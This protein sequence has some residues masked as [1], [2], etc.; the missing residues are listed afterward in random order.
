M[1]KIP[2][3]EG[4][5]Q[6]ELA[7]T[8]ETPEMQFFE[9][10][11]GLPEFQIIQIIELSKVAGLA[12][13]VVF[14]EDV[15]ERLHGTR[16]GD[17]LRKA[18]QNFDTDIYERIALCGVDA[19]DFLRA[20]LIHQGIV[21]AEEARSIATACEYMEYDAARGLIEYINQN[22]EEGTASESLKQVLGMTDIT[23]RESAQKTN[24]SEANICQQI[25]RIEKRLDKKFGVS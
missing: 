15:I 17:G 21:S 18:L 22:L 2:V 4:S 24:T 10:V 3:E 12:R 9:A 13:G 5:I 23:Q 8:Y 25:R 19:R 14:L 20:S 6:K 1:K 11:N 7:A 16:A